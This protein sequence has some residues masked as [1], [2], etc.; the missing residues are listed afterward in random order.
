MIQHAIRVN[1][2]SGDVHAVYAMV[3]Y[4]AGQYDVALDEAA[5]ALELEPRHD[6]ASKVRALTYL[7][8]EQPREALDQLN[9]S[10]LGESSTAGAAYALLG[11]RVGAERIAH[12]LTTE[13]SQFWEAAHVWVALDEDDRALDAITRAF[14]RRESGVRWANVDPMFAEL[15]ADP[16]YQALVAQ[17]HLPE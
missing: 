4:T 6:L 12:A 7:E 16:R 11:D 8:L 5:R 15:R 13:K 3:A 2:L 17:L 1:P 14:D 10:D 9:A